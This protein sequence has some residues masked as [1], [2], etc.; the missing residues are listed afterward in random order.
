VNAD[1]RAELAHGLK[2]PLAIILGY[3]ELLV[4]RDDDETRKNATEQI[5]A[6]AHRLRSSIDS[7]LGLQD[8]PVEYSP[9]HPTTLSRRSPSRVLIIDDDVFVRRLLRMTLP[10]DE[11]EIAEA[12]DGDIALAVAEA[13]RPELVLLDWCMPTVSGDAV[14]AELKQ[15]FP[16]LAV[17]VLT[18]AAE[19]R[20]RAEA[21]GADG[22]LTKPFSPLELLR[23]VEQLLAPMRRGTATQPA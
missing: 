15:R 4:L 13:H 11:F 22:F 19:Q 8:D 5:T 17:I 23:T 6:A 2:T 20:A 16:T 18:A 14:L 3:A 7:I 1:E 10:A 12:C 9:S 21:L